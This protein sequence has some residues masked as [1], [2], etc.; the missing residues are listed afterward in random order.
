MGVPGKQYYVED[1][2]LLLSTQ[3]HGG[4]PW[5]LFAFV[6]PSGNCSISLCQ[7]IS[8]VAIFRRVLPADGVLPNDSSKSKICQL[9]DVPILPQLVAL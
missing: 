1:W 5:T 8:F 2:H 4:E 9:L 3:L 7:K 6:C